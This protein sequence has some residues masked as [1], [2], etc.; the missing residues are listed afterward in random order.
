VSLFQTERLTIALCPEQVAILRS[1]PG[2]EKTP[3]EPVILEVAPLTGMPLWEG[4]LMALAD[5]LQH[6]PAS[7]ATASLVLSSRFVRFALLPW[8]EAAQGQ[9]ETQALASACFESQY[10]DMR[11]WTLRVDEGFY[12]VPRL[13][14]AIET[15]LLDR[16]QSVFEPRK[17]ACRRIEPYF[18]TCWN[19]WHKEVQGSDALF[20]VAE[21][22]VMVVA[23]MKDSR[24][25]GVRSLGGVH[26]VHRLAGVMSREALLQGFTEAPAFWLHAPAF[27][28][29]LATE[30]ADMLHLLSPDAKGCPIQ[31]MTRVGIEGGNRA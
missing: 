27:D 8:S 17:I 25:H 24:W 5:W 21:S 6:L 9:A 12:G 4:A 18:V 29:G 7:R 26:D 14:C 30:A 2:R 11:G 13:A 3:A 16:L 22:G 15:A 28:P 31:L 10:E 19:R 1:A 20:A 23:T